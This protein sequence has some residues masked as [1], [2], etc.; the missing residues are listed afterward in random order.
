MLASHGSIHEMYTVHQLPHSMQH[1]YMSRAVNGF[2]QIRNQ[3]KPAMDL[4]IAALL[5]D[6]LRKLGHSHSIN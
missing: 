6:A 4:Y 5:K 3:R 2:A 1:I